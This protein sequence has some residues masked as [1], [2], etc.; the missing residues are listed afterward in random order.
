MSELDKPVGGDDGSTEDRERHAFG[1]PV[2]NILR[3]IDPNDLGRSDYRINPVDSRSVYASLNEDVRSMARDVRGVIGKDLI[4]IDAGQ[5]PDVLGL[6]NQKYEPAQILV[7]RSWFGMAWTGETH[8][9]TEG[10]ARPTPQQN[11][12]KIMSMTRVQC[13]SCVQP[14][15]KRRDPNFPLSEVLKKAVKAGDEE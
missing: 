5:V 11:A 15:C 13:S 9:A 6:I 14:D 4:C 10:K 2:Q 12:E 1:V 8:Y 3:A 7:E